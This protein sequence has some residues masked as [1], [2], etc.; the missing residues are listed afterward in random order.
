MSTREEIAAALQG[1]FK[2][3]LDADVSITSELSAADV[4][5]W[6]SLNHIRLMVA[7]QKAFGVKFTA[8]EVGNL[9][10]VGELMTLIERTRGRGAGSAG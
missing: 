5:A 8:A 9:K 1:I 3:V 10:T 7:V 2:K 6:D 4:P